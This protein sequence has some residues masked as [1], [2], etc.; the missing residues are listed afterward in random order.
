VHAAETK[1]FSIP[2]S[3]ADRSL[4]EFSSQSGVELV[5]PGE[6]VR[7]VRTPAVTGDLTPGV[8]LSRLLR[9]TGLTSV[10]DEKTGAFSI[11]RASDS[12]VR[13]AAQAT[14]SD[15]PPPTTTAHF[16]RSRSSDCAAVPISRIAAT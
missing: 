16:I 15:R 4:K 10:Q 1:S 9:G 11:S 2:A 14:P 7:G 12:N 6:I 13:R 5:H 8:A 3:T